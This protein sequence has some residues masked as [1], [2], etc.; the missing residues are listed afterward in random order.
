MLGKR[1][2]EIEACRKPGFVNLWRGRKKRRKGRKVSD[3]V[4]VR[5]KSSNISCNSKCSNSRSNTRSKQS[6]SIDS[7][8]ASDISSRDLKSNHQSFMKGKKS[9]KDRKASHEVL[10]SKTSNPSTNEET[11]TDDSQYTIKSRKQQKVPGEMSKSRSSP[12]DCGC[13]TCEHAHNGCDPSMSSS[14]LASWK[15]RMLNF[16]VNKFSAKKSKLDRCGITRLTFAD[17]AKNVVTSH[18][19]NY[20]VHVAIII[21]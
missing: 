21:F 18:I 20:Q 16:C 14:T 11:E 5:S 19:K 12:E 13:S 8:K 2:T 10:S 4:K 17:V 15:D 3:D 7:Y 9:G 1:W 6:D